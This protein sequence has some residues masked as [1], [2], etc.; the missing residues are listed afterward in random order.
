MDVLLKKL[1]Q[2]LMETSFTRMLNIRYPVIMAPM[3]LVSN[4]KMVVAALECGITAAIPALNYRTDQ[5]L[6]EAIYEIR[7]QSDQAFGINLIVN[8][9]NLKFKRQLNT[10]LELKVDF[11]I[12]SLGNPKSTIEQCRKKGIRVFCDVINLEYA[13]KVEQLGADGV[14]AVNCE[15][16]GHAGNLRPQELIPLLKKHLRIPV[17]SAGGIANNQ[18]LK[19]VME[20][21]ADGV[22]IG[23]VF[24][25]SEESPVSPEYKKAL[26]EYGAEDIVR[27]SKLT[28]TPLTVINTPFVQ[29]IGT[30]SNLLEQM[31]NSSKRL[32]KYTKMLVAFKG[33]S[34]VRKA[35]FQATYK[36]VWCAG[37]SI[38]YIHAI[39][40][41]EKIIGRIIK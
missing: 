21:G 23:T 15:A 24:I 29:K 5:E 39:E 26:V 13:L 4:V 18:H 10:C 28:G 17:I 20:L 34:L 35:A 32:K 6:R 22:S 7:S 11:I 25:A 37:P 19:S 14:I 38:E 12:T 8:R 33:M 40:P 9:S 30:R 36:T 1:V 27:T 16:G 31:I 2:W 3:F 41:V